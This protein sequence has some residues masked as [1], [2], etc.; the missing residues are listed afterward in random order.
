MAFFQLKEV[1]SVTRGQRLDAVKKHW[2]RV[3]STLVGDFKGGL[4]GCG[5]M[6]LGRIPALH[7]LEGR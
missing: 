1:T 2:L 4:W 7:L 5:I 3:E 6:P